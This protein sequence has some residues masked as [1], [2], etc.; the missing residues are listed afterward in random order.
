[1]L[2]DTSVQ[3]HHMILANAPTPLLWMIVNDILNEI[4][5]THTVLRNISLSR[6]DFIVN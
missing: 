6:L 2:L 5:H 1:M 3:R 4:C